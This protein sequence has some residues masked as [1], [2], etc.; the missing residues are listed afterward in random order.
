VASIAR[1]NHHAQKSGSSPYPLLKQGV[2][3]LS[4]KRKRNKTLTVR[5][6][7]KEYNLI[8]GKAKKAKIKAIWD[9]ITTGLLIFLMASPFLILLWIFMWFINPF[10]A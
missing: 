4:E 1:G 10:G 5:L 6:T 8:R 3:K 2:D 7:E 9:K